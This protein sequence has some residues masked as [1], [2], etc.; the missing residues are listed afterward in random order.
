MNADS[1]LKKVLKNKKGQLMTDILPTDN[2]DLK[3][4]LKN[5]MF[6]ASVTAADIED[7][8]SRVLVN[9]NDIPVGMTQDVSD[10][11]WIYISE[12][13]TPGY[14]LVYNKKNLE[15]LWNKA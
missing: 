13:V 6:R 7:K 3:A 10:V 5:V 12:Q 1:R 14:V 15:E 2:E 11:Y 8:G 9:A 4:F